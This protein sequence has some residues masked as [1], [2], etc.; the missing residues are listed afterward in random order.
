MSYDISWRLEYEDARNAVGVPRNANGVWLINTSI[1]YLAQFYPSVSNDPSDADYQDWINAGVALKGSFGNYFQ[2]QKGL[3]LTSH[4]IYLPGIY[5]ITMQY[6]HGAHLFAASMRRLYSVE[7][8]GYSAA[9]VAVDNDQEIVV[10]PADM[11]VGLDATLKPGILSAAYY[12]KVSPIGY[13]GDHFMVDARINT[14]LLFGRATQFRVRTTY[15][16]NEININ[17]YSSFRGRS[18]A[19]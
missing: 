13:P 16:Y 1:G 17:G 9:L 15:F 10:S 8:V 6:A 11:S 5:D 12:P 2:Y 14:K 19:I 7:N 18:F 4:K 3:I